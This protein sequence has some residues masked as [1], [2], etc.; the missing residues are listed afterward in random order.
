MLVLLGVWKVLE[1]AVW[2][3]RKAWIAVLIGLGLGLAG[4]LSLQAIPRGI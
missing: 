1:L 4:L 2:V 3:P